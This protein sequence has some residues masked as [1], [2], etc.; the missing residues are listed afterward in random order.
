MKHYVEAEAECHEEKRIPEEEGEEG[1]EDLEESN[2]RGN[3]A[4]G[5]T[6]PGVDCFDQL[7]RFGRPE[8]VCLEGYV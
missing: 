3:I 7:L 1:L 4:K 8:S 2:L 6:D 5:T